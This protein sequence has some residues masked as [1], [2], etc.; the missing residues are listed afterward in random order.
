MVQ[1]MDVCMGEKVGARA[2]M[3]IL[4]TDRNGKGPNRD[5]GSVRI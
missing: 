5:V 1:E 2:H 4:A 3:K